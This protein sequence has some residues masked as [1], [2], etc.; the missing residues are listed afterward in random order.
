MLLIGLPTLVISQILSTKR[1]SPMG[2]LFH[3]LLAVYPNANSGI[4]PL[5]GLEL[6]YKTLP[7]FLPK[8]SGIMKRLSV[9]LLQIAL[10][11]LS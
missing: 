8:G 3:L 7:S 10:A 5:A 11:I 1:F 9:P 4:S 6:V 2:S